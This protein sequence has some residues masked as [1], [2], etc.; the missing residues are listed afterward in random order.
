MS[1]I[2][3]LLRGKHFDTVVFSRDSHPVGHVSFAS[4]HGK[5]PFTSIQLPNPALLETRNPSSTEPT[6]LTQELWPDHCV[7]GTSGWEFHPALDVEFADF[8][9]DKGQRAARDSYSAFWR[10]AD[11]DDTTKLGRELS[12][13]GVV[14]VYCVGLAY[15][16]CVGSTAID[17]AAH[18]FKVRTFH[19]VT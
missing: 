18:G 5:Q 16:Y 3:E 7:A 4:T 14:E 19:F 11:S 2:N 6:M 15:D 17:A 10:E 12:K 13:R 9:I 1:P 8:I